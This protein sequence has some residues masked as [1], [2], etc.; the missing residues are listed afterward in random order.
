MNTIT[1]HTMLG[2]VTLTGHDLAI[3]GFAGA[4]ALAGFLL[5]AVLHRR[6]RKRDEEI[7]RRCKNR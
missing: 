1:L 6:D 3:L 4:S 7:K 2:P 5:M